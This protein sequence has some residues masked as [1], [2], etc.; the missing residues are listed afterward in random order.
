MPKP[1]VSIVIPNFNGKAHLG[2]C[3]SSLQNLT[4]RNFEIILVD[5][6]STDGSTE[7]VKVNYPNVKVLFN[8]K[9][10]GFAEGCNVGMRNSKGEYVALLNNDTEV[11]SKWL[12]ELILVAE[13]DPQIGICASKMIMFHDRKVLNSAG[14]EYDAYGFGHDRG[15]YEI[16]CSQ[17]S[18]MEEVFFACGGAML[19]RKDVLEKVGLFDSRYF[20]YGEDVDLCWRVRLHGLKVVYVP[21]SVVYHKYGGSMKPVTL[22]RFHLTNRNSLCSTLKNYDSESLATALLRFFSIKTGE[23]FL[24]LMTKRIN[25][26]IALLEM[27]FWNIRNF[28]DT[29]KERKRVQTLRRVSDKQIKRLLIKESIEIKWFMQGYFPKFKL[30]KTPNVLYLNSNNHKKNSRSLN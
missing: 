7:F 12:E 17:Y 19:I 8:H 30:K 27:L 2:T 11:D 1:L 3:L 28:P 5:N 6:G 15:L 22:Q 16:D 21:S 14:G 25:A 10:L 26:S 4:Y 18:R 23:F 29:W 9:N 20:M 24:F 13:S